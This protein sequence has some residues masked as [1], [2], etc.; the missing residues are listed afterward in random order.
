MLRLSLTCLVLAVTVLLLPLDFS[1]L[2]AGILGGLFMIFL[3]L[4][5]ST[6]DNFAA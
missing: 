1:H 3:V 2:L 5:L 6:V 4:G